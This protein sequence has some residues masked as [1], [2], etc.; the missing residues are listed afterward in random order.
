MDTSSWYGLFSSLFDTP[1]LISNYLAGVNWYAFSIAVIV[2]VLML[3]SRQEIRLRRLRSILDFLTSFR[4]TGVNETTLSTAPRVTKNTSDN[5][6]ADGPENPSFEYVKSKYISDLT[7]KQGS[8]DERR[9]NAARN[10]RERINIY[11]EIASK[12][13]RNIN[14]RLQLAALGFVLISYYGF[15][16]FFAAFGYGGTAVSCSPAD[17]CGLPISEAI[18][19][20]TFAGAY[21]AALR[22][23][24]RNL[25][26]FDL[27]AFAFIR[28]CSEI[29][30]SVVIVVLL[31]NAL[32]T[33]KLSETLSQVGEMAAPSKQSTPQ[34]SPTGENKNDS[35][36][37]KGT[38]AAADKS[39]PPS[40]A[41][42]SGDRNDEAAD[43]GAPVS[44]IPWVWLLLAPAMGLLPRSATKF[45]LTKVQSL[46]DWAKTMD[47]RFVSITRVTSLDSIDGVDFETRFR[48]EECGIYDMQNL[49]TYNPIMLFVETPYG[50][51]QCIDWVAQAQLCHIVGMEK[52]M[53]FR[54]LN[55]R[56]I[57]D[58]ER[59]I[60]SIDSPD[61]YDAICAAIL[62]APTDRLRRASKIAG[63]KFA[64]IENNVAQLDDVE[65]YFN[66][67]HSQI[68]TD[69]LT[70]AAIEHLMNWISDDLHVRRLRRL[71]NEI[72]ESLGSTSEYLK[73]S[74]RNPENAARLAQIQALRNPPTPQ[75]PVP[76]PVPVPAPAPELAPAPAL[77]EGS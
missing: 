75:A 47:D 29:I 57:F 37:S 62:L 44:H 34:N 12:P 66:W 50:I 8:D 60:D 72:A 45:T 10:D 5:G 51:Y 73:D 35:A 69:A 23:L 54:E 63:F 2:P 7:V 24:L 6:N 41:A 38:D 53:M 31:F 21:I 32:P 61:A 22:M 14:I 59:A 56:T 16:A 27:S 19:A 26:V 39:T 20:F 71:W 36:G 15:S 40:T 65:A 43:K 64:V 25:A 46:I 74:K 76:A 18:G 58:L 3:I 1:V 52:F 77:A 67:L 4:L 17:G 30:A 13:F 49:A 28:Q 68:A 70:T 9:L 33:L 55:I 11:I 42:N 48:L